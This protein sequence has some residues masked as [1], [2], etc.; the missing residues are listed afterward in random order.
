MSNTL[1]V[2]LVFTIFLIFIKKRFIKR[3]F[4]FV[5]FLLSLILSYNA[6][7]IQTWNVFHYYLGSK[8]FKELGY[9]DLYTCA[10][11]ADGE[12]NNVWKTQ[13]L[14]RDLSTYKLVE[15]AE[16]PACPRGNFSSQRWE[17]FKNDFFEL[18]DLAPVDYWQATIKDKG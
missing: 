13:E 10:L 11:E 8:Y 18:Q 6:V 5:L 9:Y 1:I 14:V 4:L 16:L 3:I 2:V 15:R 7:P 17:S 12:G